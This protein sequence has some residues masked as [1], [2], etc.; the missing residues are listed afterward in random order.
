M[1]P[2]SMPTLLAVPS[3][4]SPSAD[5]T[6]ARDLCEQIYQWTGWDWLASGSYYLLIKPLRI[7]LIILIAVLIRFLIHRLISRVARSAATPGP[8]IAALRPLRN[9]LPAAP[10]NNGVSERRRARAEALG[11]ILRSI[12]SAVVFGVAFMLVLDELGVNLAPIL[13]GAGILGLAIGFG[14]QN[15][16]RDFLSGLFMLFEDQYGVGDLVAIGEV[17]G[18]VEAVGLRITTVRDATG[19]VWYIR[20]G[21]IQKL[22][23]KS[24][25]WALVMVDIPIGFTKI[26]DAV[27]VLQRAAI[28]WAE[29]EE[30]K[31]DVI[32]APEVV[33]VEEVTTDG[34]VVRTTVKTPAEAQWRA[35]RELRRRLT[36][37]LAEAGIAEKITEAGVHVQPATDGSGPT[38]PPP[39]APAPAAPAGP[40][41][42]PNAVQLGISTAIQRHLDPPA[43][44]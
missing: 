38:D 26:D 33:G 9:R 32:E 36:E 6:D 19:T 35:A 39:A 11:S 40:P 41:I 3:Q 44:P 1:S 4:P 18:T 5:C 13:A 22:A 12:A 28:D 25:G 10:P 43:G 16:V 20:N 21:E 37:A 23:N 42:N 15:L 27:E 2:E 30:W 17:E 7:V 14:A 31:P 34:A 8:G 29:S 24:Q